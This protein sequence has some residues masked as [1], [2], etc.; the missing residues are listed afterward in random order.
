MNGAMASA[1][2]AGAGVSPS[3]MRTFIS[4]LAISFIFL[5]GA[6][7]LGKM[8]EQL[9]SGKLESAQLIKSA[10]TLVIILSIVSYLIFK[11]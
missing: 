1:F 4:V 10:V 11:I 3:S 2:T 7:L 9:N 5:F 8:I 6:W